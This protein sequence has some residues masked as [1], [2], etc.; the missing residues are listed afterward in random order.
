VVLG[1]KSPRVRHVVDSHSS[2][3]LGHCRA[4]LSHPSRTVEPN[5]SMCHLSVQQVGTL[6]STETQ[7]SLK[8]WDDTRYGAAI[9]HALRDGV[10]EDAAWR[11]CQPDPAAGL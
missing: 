6:L 7:S 1:I 11:W 9:E 2:S 3:P 8:I 10:R 4:A 5:L